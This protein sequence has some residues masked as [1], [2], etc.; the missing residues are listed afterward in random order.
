MVASLKMSNSVLEINEL[1]M[2]GTLPSIWQELAGNNLF[3]QPTYIT[4]IANTLPSGIELKLVTGSHNGKIEFIAVCQLYTFNKS[5]L[6]GVQRAVYKWCD[7]KALGRSVIAKSIIN[8]LSCTKCKLLILGSILQTGNQFY[9]ALPGVDVMK[10]LELLLSYYKKSSAIDAFIIKDNNTL[11]LKGS[12]P[13][14]TQPNMVLTMDKSWKTYD[15]YVAALLPKYRKRINNTNNKNTALV[16]KELSAAA[17]KK[18]SKIMYGLYTN[19]YNAS[20]TKVGMVSNTYFYALMASLGDKC[21]IKGFY[22]DSVM[23]GFSVSL[24]N[25]DTLEAN[26]IGLDYSLNKSMKLYQTI[27]NNYVKQAIDLQCS[28][29]S[30]GRTGLEIKSTVGAEPEYLNCAISLL[31]TQI[32]ILGKP[33]LKNIKE[34]KFEQRHPL[35]RKL[36]D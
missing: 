3:L 7:V 15:D 14:Y 34:A 21:S 27:L 24:Q 11:Q 32:S 29:L 25:G 22:V 1:P 20:E 35:K 10:Y 9:A 13:F 17:V 18:E 26:F 33:I 12:L 19:V 30:L 16:V 23:V 31:N 2:D 5:H 6:S 36:M 28:K 8:Y 4:A